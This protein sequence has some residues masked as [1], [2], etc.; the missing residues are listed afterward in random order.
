MEFHVRDERDQRT[1]RHRG[2]DELTPR[3]I[4][5]LVLIAAGLTDVAISKF[6]FVSDSTVKRHVRDILSK[7]DARNRA[8]AVHHGHRKG[9][10]Q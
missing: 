4:E 6:L 8:N 3:Q 2:K 9:L 7:L 1:Y 10:L 5:V